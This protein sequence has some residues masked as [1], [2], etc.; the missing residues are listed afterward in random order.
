MHEFTGRSADRLADAYALGM[1]A[2]AARRRAEEL[3]PGQV[4]ALHLHEA[5]FA[6][7]GERVRWETVFVR[8]KGRAG[9]GVVAAKIQRSEA[10]GWEV[11]VRPHEQTP[12]EAAELA[13]QVEKLLAAETAQASGVRLGRR[14]AASLTAD[15][16]KAAQR[17]W[18][19]GC[20]WAM[21]QAS[22]IEWDRWRCAAA[23]HAAHATRWLG[24]GRGARGG[25][26]RGE[27]G[28]EVGDRRGVGG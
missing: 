2:A 25:R 24:A 5:L 11:S 27:S 1:R 15:E 26:G 19:E 23:R 17:G 18:L 8:R 6:A 4:G 7:E 13:E 28:G 22:G 20:L 9:G 10:G 21:A 14:L 3:D 12:A 16:A